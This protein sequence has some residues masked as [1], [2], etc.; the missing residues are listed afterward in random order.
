[1]G[2]HSSTIVAFLMTFFNLRLGWWLPNPGE[3]GKGVWKRSEPGF[4]LIPLVAEAFG[5]TTDQTSYVYLSDGGHF[6]N[7]A[8]Y[9]MVFRRC[10]LIVLVD[11]GCDP[12]YEYEDLAGAVRKIRNDMGI[13]ITF[14]GLPRPAGEKEPGSHYG[15]GTVH[16][17]EVGEDRDGT[18]IYIKP[19][20]TGDE[21]VDVRRYAAAH[22]KPKNPFPQQSTMDQFFDEAQFESYRKLGEHSVLKL[23]KQKGGSTTH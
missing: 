5:R 6:E 11:A 16:Y 10:G 2:Y 21:D 19:V 9:E 15:I 8:L 23:F 14:S 4:G 12:K 3:A 18:I 17:T 20:L 13:P 7:L 1:M 22:K